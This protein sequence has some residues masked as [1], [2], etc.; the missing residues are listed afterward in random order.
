[1]LSI[2]ISAALLSFVR[3]W[4]HKEGDSM[5]KHGMWGFLRKNREKDRE[6]GGFWCE[7]DREE[8]DAEEALYALELLRQEQEAEELLRDADPDDFFW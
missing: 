6:T 7:E 4:I 3:Q 8:D 2:R 5:R 1:M